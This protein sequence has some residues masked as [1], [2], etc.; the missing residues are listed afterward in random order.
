MLA[1]DKRGGHQDLYDSDCRSVIH[2]IHERIRVV[3]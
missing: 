2:Y 3:L 1:M